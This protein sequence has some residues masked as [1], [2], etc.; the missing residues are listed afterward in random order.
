MLTLVGYADVE[1]MQGAIFS[2]V[3]SAIHIIQW[4]HLINPV[5]SDSLLLCLILCVRLRFILRISI[6]YLLL[7]ELLFVFKLLL[8]IGIR[9]VSLVDQIWLKLLLRLTKCYRLVWCCI[10]LNKPALYAYKQAAGVFAG[11]FHS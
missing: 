10:S 9:I 11:D 4:L 1:R 7:L 8:E 3:T 6:L 5:I 2:F